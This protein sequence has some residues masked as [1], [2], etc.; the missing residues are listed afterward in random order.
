V[1]GVR[2]RLGIVQTFRVQIRNIL[3]SRTL[4]IAASKYHHVA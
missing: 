4:T 3:G 2:V 1:N